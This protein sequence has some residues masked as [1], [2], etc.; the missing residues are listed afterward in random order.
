MPDDV[1]SH[2]QLLNV[3]SH[4]PQE[5]D[6]LL[7]VLHSGSFEDLIRQFFPI[8]EKVFSWWS[9]RSKDWRHSDR[10]RRLDH[11]WATNSI[12]KRVSK[13]NILKDARGWDKPSD[14]VPIL[15]EI[16]LV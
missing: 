12:S 2:K 5:T 15:V 13:V 14:H 4:T 16:E 3:V 10:G 8:P 9:Y 11:I 7:D 6:L 1:W